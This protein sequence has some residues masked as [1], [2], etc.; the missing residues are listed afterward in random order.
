MSDLTDSTSLPRTSGEDSFLILRY[1]RE[2][3]QRR[4]EE[5]IKLAGVNSPRII[6][7]FSREVTTSHDEL[8]SDTSQDGFEQTAGLTASRISLVGND[9]LELDI[10]IGDVA[11]HLKANDQIDH[12]RV[13]LRYM[14]LLNRPKMTSENNP[15][16]VE[17][18]RRGIWT[19]CRENGL[20]LEQN[21]DLL[22]S[23]EEAFQTRLPEVYMELNGLLEHHHIE[24]AQVHVIRQQA[25]PGGQASASSGNNNSGNAGNSGSQPIQNALSSLQQ[26]LQQQFSANESPAGQLSDGAIPYSAGNSGSPGNAGNIT[27]SASTLVMLN[28]LMERLSVLEMQQFSGLS[29]GPLGE[30]TGNAPLRALRSKDLDLPLGKPASIALDTLSLIFEAIFSAPDLPDVVK[31]SIS[32]LQIPLLK[33]AIIDPSFF[34]D[35][36]HPA[37]QLINRMARAATGLAEDTGRDHPVCASLGKLADDIRSSLESNESD[38]SQHIQELDALILE[39]DQSTQTLAHPYIEL[40]S[41]YETHASALAGARSW[42][43]KTRSQVSRPE[44]IS[45][46]SE[47][48]LRVMQEA[49]KA[50]GT[51][52][53]RWRESELTID[54]LLWSIEPKNT[55]EERSN[56]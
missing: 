7:A 9:D 5:I 14:T 15:V 46:L 12:W 38:L 43:L 55:A 27:L 23:M 8:A 10:R 40:V 50:G 24:P 47:C 22:D 6:D 4:L 36:Q 25:G 45:F 49:H 51:T 16:G 13:Q 3:F 2:H 18:I 31:A 30:I 20:T 39:R 44:I 28:H 34:N 41:E 32:R 56:C 11:N 48:W 53:E 19:I 33:Q 54:E 52:G 37:R 29:N 1:C 26:A 17:P 35:S 42:L 21:L